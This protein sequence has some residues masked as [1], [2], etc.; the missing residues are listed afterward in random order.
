MSVGLPLGQLTIPERSDAGS[1]LVFGSSRQLIL[2]QE[3]WRRRS[4]ASAWVA[5]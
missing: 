5:P 2:S 4:A 3:A 1:V